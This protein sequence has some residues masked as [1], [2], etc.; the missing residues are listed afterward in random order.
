MIE[1]TPIPIPTSPA[2]DEPARAVAAPRTARQRLVSIAKLAL[3]LIIV[4]FVIRALV[5]QFRAV[6]W[7]QLNVTPGFAALATLALLALSGVQLLAFVSL[8][9]GYG[10]RLPWRAALA[11]AW[12]PPLGKYVPGKVASIA[13]AVYIQR[14]YGVPGSVAV[15]VALMMDGLAVIAGLIVSTPLLLWEP[16]R[17]QMPSAWA[18]C[19]ALAACGLVALHPRVFA[20]LVNF[21]LKK[22]GRTPL[23]SVPSLRTYAIPLAC[24]F[25][26]WLFAG[27]ALWLMTRAVIYVIPGAL[28][29]FI[30]TAA[31][32]MTV[33][34]LALFSP[35]GIGV[36]EWLFLVTLGP[37]IGPHA[38][39]VI[40]AMRVVQT[41]IEL[42]LAGAGFAALRGAAAAAT[43]KS[44]APSPPAPSPPAPV[45][46]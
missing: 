32:A 16:V 38:A 35:G 18:W 39:I 19:A 36:R 4:A 2:E 42:G 45:S 15:S 9:R 25:A 46:S 1:S 17:K 27:L 11:A 31:L 44:P 21:L 40:V 33:S 28:P 41:L 5:H 6:A 20:G 10:H 34:Y 22:L 14:Q 26:Q 13:G 8:L 24:A 30:A 7:D 29:L 3:T 37:A 12:I 43:V 23:A